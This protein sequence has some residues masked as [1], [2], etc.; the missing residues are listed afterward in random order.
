MSTTPGTETPLLR[1]LSPALRELQRSVS[2]WLSTKHF[3]PVSTLTRANLQG[4]TDDLKRKSESLEMQKPLLVIMLMGGTGVGKSTLLNALA[5]RPI[6][7]S[8]FTRPTTRDP[9]VYYHESI[10]PETLDPALQHCRLA[11]H[12]RPE[13]EQKILVDTPDLDSN[14]IANREKLKNLLPVADIVLYVGSQEKYHD[15]LGWDLFLHQRKRRAFAFVLNKWDRCLHASQSGFRPDDDLIQELKSEGFAEPLVFRTC[16]QYW[17]DENTGAEQKE[18]LPDGEQYQDLVRWLEMGLDRLEIEAIKSRG[19]SQLLTHLQEALQNA[20]PPNLEKEATLTKQVWL[21]SLAEQAKSDSAV[22]LD[23]LEPYQKEIEHYFALERQ[24]NFRGIMAGYLQIYNR[25]KYAGSQLRDRVPFV[26]SAGNKSMAPTSW[27]LDQFTRACIKAA[28]ERHLDASGRALANRLLVEADEV[29]FPLDLL[30]GTTEQASNIDWRGRYSQAL[31]DVLSQVELEWTRPT[32]WRSWSRRFVIILTDW[33]PLIT[34]LAAYAVPL[35]QYFQFEDTPSLM[36]FIL[37][38]VVLLVVLVLLHVLVM[39]FL[40]LRWQAIRGQFERLLEIR[41][42]KDLEA[43][44][45]GL[46]AEVVEQLK[47]ERRQVEQILSEVKEVSGWLE[48]RESA[49][50]IAGLYGH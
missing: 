13:L 10:H 29:D 24:T 12:D 8:S 36:D 44:Y 23:T 18:E 35:F 34:L 19:V 27:D 4:L 16:A 45:A 31:V 20:M 6:A 47:K 5:G 50:S 48:Q 11:Q 15:K 7:Q 22:L 17:V 37:P 3:Q 40:P 38:L 39:V 46:P 43:V 21:K 32:G 28:S 25:M 26:G 1:T 9:V 49:A 30:S 42:R 41:L 14:D 33:V 2:T